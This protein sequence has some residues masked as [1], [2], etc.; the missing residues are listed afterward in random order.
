MRNRATR[1]S[2]LLIF[3]LMASIPY[4]GSSLSAQ[5]TQPAQPPPP[6]FSAPPIPS[7]SRQPQ[8]AHPPGPGQPTESFSETP[9]DRS[10]AGPATPQKPSVKKG[11]VS[12]N[13]DDADVY[14]VIQTIFGGIMKFNYIIDPKVK[15][16]VNFRSIAPVAKEDVLPLMEVIL[17]LNGIG[18]IEE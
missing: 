12:F 8:P 2:L 15:G 3:L 7:P 14:S 11:E 16:R 18:V 6:L 1:L 5:S 17:R 4:K 13:F 10:K 9:P